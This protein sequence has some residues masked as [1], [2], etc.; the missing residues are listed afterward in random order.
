MS[1]IPIDLSREPASPTAKRQGFWH[2]LALRIDA[3]VACAV[4]HAVS[5]QELR[6]ADADIRRCRELI[7][8]KDLHHNG[9][10]ARVRP[11]PVRIKVR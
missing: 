4:R 10:L 6:R 2:S 7:A 1:V 3:L 5:E 8:Q 9:D 11:H